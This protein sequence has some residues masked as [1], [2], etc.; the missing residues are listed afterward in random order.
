MRPALINRRNEE[1]EE[2][3]KADGENR[4]PEKKKK[5][6]K[7][8]SVLRHIRIRRNQAAAIY[9]RWRQLIPHARVFEDICPLA[10]R[11]TMAMLQVLPKVV[12]AIKLLALIA[13]AELMLCGEMVDAHGP[14]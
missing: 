2:E 9:R 4:L 6:K 13:F 11:T 12:G 14:V 1:E 10:A 5:N 3:E 8:N 7:K